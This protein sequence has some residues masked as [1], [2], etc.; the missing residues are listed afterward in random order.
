MVGWLVVVV[1][2]GGLV[3]G[4]GGWWWSLSMP[5]VPSVMSW[6]VGGGGCYRWCRAALPVR[7]AADYCFA[8]CLDAEV[9]LG[10]Y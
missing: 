9:S 8:P 6:W 1:G 5:T 4:G 7:Y 2:G 10:A 3:G